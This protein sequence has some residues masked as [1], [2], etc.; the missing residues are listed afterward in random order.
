[1]SKIVFDLDGVLRDIISYLEKR[2][3]IPT[4]K[5]WYWEHE[6]KDIYELIEQDN[7]RALTEA[8]STNYLKS[9]IENFDHL[10]IWT[11]QPNE[12]MPYTNKW[13]DEHIRG[14]VDCEIKIL[15]S[16]VKEKLL[17]YN[18]TYLVEDYPNFKNYRN[19]I[20]VD[21]TYNRN[22]ICK[23]RIKNGKELMNKIKELNG[24]S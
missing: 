13:I 8:K 16:E 4:I 15:S 10:E 3:N 24:N 2:Y 9:I 5:E 17:D 11:N 6:K 22:I 12:W 1:M 7:Y 21:R 23:H 19:I 14:Y 18:N 20:L